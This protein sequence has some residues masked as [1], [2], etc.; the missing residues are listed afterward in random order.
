MALLLQEVLDELDFEADLVDESIR[1]FCIMKVYVAP[2][3]AKNASISSVLPGD[4]NKR[5]ERI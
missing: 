1:L 4:L 2:V 3:M 5:L